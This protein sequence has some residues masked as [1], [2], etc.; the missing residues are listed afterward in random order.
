MTE[1]SSVPERRPQGAGPRRSLR[2]DLRALTPAERGLWRHPLMWLGTLV[3]TAVPLL[4]STVYLSSVWDPYGHLGDLPVGVVNL[5][6]G[7]TREGRPV[8][9]GAQTL[10]GLREDPPV[11]LVSYRTE[12]QAQAAVRAGQVYFALTFPADFSR[13]AVGGRSGEHGLLHLYTA[14]GTSSFASRVGRSVAERLAGD[15]NARLGTSR[16]EVVQT[17]LGELDRGLADLKAATGRLRDGAASLDA[18]ATRLAEGAQTLAEGTA[19]LGGGA[20]A[21]ATGARDLSGGVTRLT[22]GNAELGAALRKVEAAAPG[23]AQLA[24][25]RAGAGGLV[26]GSA[27]LADGVTAL[28]AGAA[29]L[30]TGARDLAAG[31]GR[32]NAGAG[33]LAARSPRLADGLGQL[34]QGAAG[35]AGGATDLADGAA[36]VNAGAGQLAA[37]TPAL[38]RG[39]RD[40]AAGAERLAAGARAVAPGTPLAQGARDLQTGAATL[41]EGADQAARGAGD[42]AEGAGTLAAA[43]SSLREGAA[44]LAARTGEAATGAQGLA[45]GSRALAA[46][47]ARLRAG[48]QDLGTG[49]QTLAA[50]ADEA[51][52]GARQLRQ[53]ARD[54]Q[55][56]VGLLAD[57]NVRLK[58]ALGQLTAR[59]PTQA[60]L[61][62]LEGGAATLAR[63]SGD[64]AGGAARVEGGAR[65]LAGGARDLQAGTARLRAGLGELHAKVPPGVVPLVGDPEGL[66]QSVRVQ[67]VGTAAVPNNGTA[68]APYFMALALWVGVTLTTF[69]FPY[70]T[71]PESGRGTGRLAR[72]LR[73]AAVPALVVTAQALL[74]V[75]GVHLLGVEYGH[76]G[77]VLLTTVASSLTF[78]AVVL[79]LVTLLGS[80]GRLLALILLIVQLAASGGTYPVELSGPLFQALHRVMPITDTVRALRAT[81]FGSY[82]GVYAPALGHLALTGLVAAALSLLGRRW[83]FVPDGQVRPAL[84]SEGQR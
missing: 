84:L 1:E 55:A 51:G 2:G 31:A 45:E 18:G 59:L 80:A 11:R 20:Q 19:R 17:R 74:V 56:G 57:G 3:V 79:A 23:E 68:F 70:T 76:L 9:V 48:A 8:N 33:Q 58:S 73:K 7:T 40:L 60:D 42:L 43:T 53:G 64:L 27:R 82:D 28:G 83:L 34:R 38:A 77:G 36:R 12:A 22:G 81:L 14:E 61:D 21:L 69:V 39:A 63:G 5:D 25:L 54:L 66:A 15:I 4:Y 72:V 65:D 13:R 41:A 44:T 6:R 47:T 24:P 29:R 37:R 49:A 52:R 71:L 50:R 62:G 35:L 46:G 10:A 67:E 32:V 26:A 78:L 75:L 16:W 30:G